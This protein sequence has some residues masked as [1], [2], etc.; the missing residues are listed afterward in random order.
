MN[1]Q[2]CNDPATRECIDVCVSASVLHVL[3]LNRQ[4]PPLQ[5]FFAVQT[6]SEFGLQPNS[7]K[8]NDHKM[9]A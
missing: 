1:V 6:A 3:F 5:G 8:N 7:K 4:P 9:S 2:G